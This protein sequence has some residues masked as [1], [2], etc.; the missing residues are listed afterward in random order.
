MAKR[1]FVN[2]KQITTDKLKQIEKR[3]QELISRGTAEDLVKCKVICTV[4]G[5]HA[6]FGMARPP[7]LTPAKPATAPKKRASKTTTKKT[8]GNNQRIN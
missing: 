7:K 3:N 1:Y 2:G 8:I 5:E 4:D 6:V